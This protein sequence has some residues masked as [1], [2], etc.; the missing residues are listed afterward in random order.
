MTKTDHI[1]FDGFKIWATSWENHRSGL[2]PGPTQTRLYSHRRWIEAW[3]FGFRKQRD[4]TI[5]VAK[6]KALISFAVIA[7]LI[8][9]FVFTYAKC[10]FS[11]E[12]AH[13][14]HGSIHTSSN[15]LS[16]CR[17]QCLTEP[18]NAMKGGVIK[19]K[20]NSQY[21]TKSTSKFKFVVSTVKFLNFRTPEKVAVIY[22]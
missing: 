17:F 18:A 2:R 9:V 15:V 8:C 1:V 4:C 7:K 22:L 12:A 6:T 16:V 14:K 13:V 11:H 19:V 10:W 3:N 5:Y 21:Q 20:V